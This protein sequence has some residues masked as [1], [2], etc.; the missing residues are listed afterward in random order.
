MCSR[1]IL[2][3]LV[4]SGYFTVHGQLQGYH[5]AKDLSDAWLSANEQG[6]Y[7][8]VGDNKTSVV[9]LPLD[10]NAYPGG[11]LQVKSSSD[12]SFYINHKLEYLRKRD[13]LIDLDSLSKHKAPP[14]M[15]SI[16][17]RKRAALQTIVLAK[18]NTEGDY[19]PS[20][21][22]GSYF[23]DLSIIVSLILSFFFVILLRT[24][25]KHTLDYL[26]LARLFSLKEREDT[27]LNSRI[28]SSA[29]ILY[30]V[31]ISM[32]CGFILLLVFNVAGDDITVARHFDVSA[33]GQ[34]LLLWAELTLLVA[35]L[36]VAKLIL[37]F[38]LSNLFNSR[39]TIPYQFY[40]FVRLLFFAFGIISVTTLCYFVF[41]IQN[42]AA[43]SLLIYG[44]LIALIFWI[45][46]IGLKLL[47]QSSFKSF[48]LFSYLCASELIPVVFIIKVLNS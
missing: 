43:Y 21:R 4:C 34:G 15:I 32:L 12:F 39:E 28:S 37:I 10:R 20:L 38:L 3:I 40:N 14:W 24:N 18:E 46:L 19:V 27:L 42:P 7:L 11:L 48:Q 1:V 36:L 22:R 45:V 23:L 17:Q 13:L 16:S 9:H 5:L 33:L 8:S 6:Q 25:P 29:N 41:K 47:S 30:Y 2:L 44:L 31:F 35:G 26:N